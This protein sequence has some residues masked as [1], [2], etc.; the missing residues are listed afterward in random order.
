MLPLKKILCPIDFSE[1]SY[2]ALVSAEELARHFFSE[3]LVVH[4]VAPVPIVSAPAGQMSFNVPLYQEELKTSSQ[5]SLEEI[6]RERVHADIK[7]QALV[8]MGDPANEIVR[9]SEEEDVDLV[10]LSSHGLTGWRH[11]I[12]G[13]V[14]E[15]VIRRC[16][17]PIVC[18]PVT[19][20]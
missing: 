11:L 13:S 2:A 10:I 5:K 3:L 14:A 4:I 15:K 8:S 19:R 16:A 20:E 12:F 18:I 17:K 9:I 1:Y 7:V 6:T